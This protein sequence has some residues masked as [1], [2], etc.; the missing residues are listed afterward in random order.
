MDDADKIDFL[1]VGQGLA[2]TIIS[3]EISKRGFSFKIIDN[4][5]KNSAS[6]AAGGMMHPMSFK[7]LIPSWKALEF[8]KYA[9][10][11]YHNI[12]NKTNITFYEDFQLYRPFDSIEEQ[13]DWMAKMKD[14]A[15]ENLLSITHNEVKGVYQPFGVGLVNYSGKLDVVNFLIHFKEKFKNQLIEEF[16]D[17]EALS[18]SSENVVYKG[19]AYQNVIFCEGYQYINNPYFGYLPNNI[20][21][22]EI[23]EFETDSLDR[24][25]ISKGCFIAPLGKGNHSRF[26]LGSTYEWNNQDESITERGKIE[27]EEKLQ[28]LGCQSYKITTQKCGIRPTTH[29]RRPLVGNHPIHKN[30][31]IFNGMGSKTVMMAPLMAKQLIDNIEHQSE[32]F[33]EAD[34]KRL[35]KKNFHKFVPL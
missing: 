11:F 17:F 4:R 26:V 28:N 24:K 27:L 32:I 23:L 12:Q 3:E 2:G 15:Y 14:A 20:T 13:N 7:R 33:L 5:H 16:F 1:I 25:M 29:D 22:G 9:Q 31:Y 19:C 21:K 8:V 30:L 34:I 18:V 10:S 35:E 6:M